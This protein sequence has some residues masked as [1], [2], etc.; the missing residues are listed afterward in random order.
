[1]CREVPAP[2]SHPMLGSLEL[3]AGSFPHQSSQ[4]GQQSCLILDKVQEGGIWG[5]QADPH[6]DPDISWALLT[7]PE[8][9]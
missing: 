5:S 1:M 3:C 8:G 6:R 4:Q 7:T 2:Y 9:P